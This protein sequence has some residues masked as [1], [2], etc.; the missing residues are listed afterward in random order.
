MADYQ[1]LLLKDEGEVRLF[2]MNRPEVY[3]PIDETSAGELIAALEEADRAPSI[4]ALVL[5]GAGKA[6]SGGGNLKAMAQ[7]LESGA[8]PGRFFLGLVASFN[9]LII[10]MRRLNK[11][12]VCAVNGVASGGGVALA[13]AC[14]LIL[15]VDGA[16]FDPGYI[17]IALSPDGGN[18]ALVSRLA[19]LKRASEFFMLGRPLSAAQALE[20]GLVNQLVEPEDLLPQALECARNL[21]QMPAGALASTKALLNAAVL[22]DLESVLENERR[23]MAN[24]SDQP[25]FSEGVNA[26]SEKRK[27]RFGA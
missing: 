2:T 3:N 21:G 11:P 22:P 17:R 6:F 15:A 26:F 10:T 20:W 12:V 18:T 16:L 1:T 4:R 14:D 24:L 19:G 5:T 9:R 23:E 27:P 7:V 13:L 8:L 25:D